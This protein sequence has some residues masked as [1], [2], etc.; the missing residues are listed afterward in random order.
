MNLIW[1]KAIKSLSSIGIGK[2]PGASSLYKYVWRYYG[3]KGIRLT[4]VNGF[5]MYVICR[6]W[7][8]APTMMFAHTW[9]PEETKLCKQYIKRGMMVIDAGAYIGYYSVLASKLVG[10]E[11]R[12]Y[13][14]EPSPECVRLLHKNIQINKC[15]NIRVFKKAIAEKKGYVAFYLSSS[16]LSGSTMFEHYS[17]S[18]K[19]LQIKVPVVSLDQA[20]GN[21]RVDFIKMDIE[22]GET[23][24]LKGMTKI[25]ENNPNL[26]MILEVFPK[27]LEE[28]GS[29]LGEYIG[30]LQ[31]YFDLYI[32]G[33]NGLIG[34]VGLWDIR[35]AAQ[36]SGVIN[37][38]CQRR[39]A[40]V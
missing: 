25:I 34:E 20:I 37:L 35:R 8:V 18:Q 13:A 11:G 38:F 1:G 19:G 14:F 10:K 16:N 22:G 40:G 29:S 3:P 24:A 39:S 2:I 33:G 23:K 31:R 26:K 17:T 32:I 36:K 30:F 21:G 9:E 12:V 6:D 27:G 4:K 28:V 15:K 7:A 5:K